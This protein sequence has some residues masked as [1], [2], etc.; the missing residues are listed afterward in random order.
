MHRNTYELLCG[1]LLLRPCD[2]SNSMNI[3]AMC[4]VPDKLHYRTS[5]EFHLTH[6]FDG[7]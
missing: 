1:E 6:E 3:I 4:A 2:S 5:S 7:M